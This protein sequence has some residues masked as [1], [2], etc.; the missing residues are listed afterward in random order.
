MVAAEDLR[1][2]SKDE[3]FTFD[4][5]ILL[6]KPTLQLLIKLCGIL[7]EDEIRLK[8]I[9]LRCILEKEMKKFQSEKHEWG[10]RVPVI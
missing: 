8:L 10:Q 2:E 9:D 6:E 7:D 4:Y 5:T 1:C 3:S